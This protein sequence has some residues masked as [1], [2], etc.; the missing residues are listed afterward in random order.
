MATAKQD[1][2]PQRGWWAPGDYFNRCHRCQDYFT[3]DKRAGICADC[4]YS[5]EEKK[6]QP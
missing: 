2:R 1:D 6:G 3:G 5:D 4:A